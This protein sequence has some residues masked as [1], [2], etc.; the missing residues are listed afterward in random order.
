MMI[1]LLVSTVF[2][3]AIIASMIGVGGGVFYIPLLLSQGVDTHHVVV[4]S[5]LLTFFTSASSLIVFR[6]ASL[7]DWRL[8][9][10]LLPLM[11][12]GAVMGGHFSQQVDPVVLKTML[13]SVLAISGILIIIR[14]GDGGET[15]CTEDES[16]ICGEKGFLVWRH[17]F[18]GREYDIPLIASAPLVLF[19]GVVVGLV[20]IG[21]GVVNVPLMILVFRMP[22]H[23]AAGTSALMMPFATAFAF[24]AHIAGGNFPD[25][26][27]GSLGWWVLGGL[28]FAAVLGSQ[29]GPRITVK[30]DRGRVR[31]IFGVIMIMI[32][33]WIIL[34]T[35]VIGL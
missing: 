32:S 19:T 28:V 5:L 17:C 26:A 1:A 4:I 8:A 12:A 25:L 6:K 10:A 35:H 16:G 2:A 23:V 21:G 31:K 7:A 27:K 29:L 9:A 11:L 33:I 30:T 18:G 22:A 34:R 20:G 3:I 13:G 24:T 15:L 14:K